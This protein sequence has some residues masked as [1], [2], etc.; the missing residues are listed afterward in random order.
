MAYTQK[1]KF[2]SS[3]LINRFDNKPKLINNTKTPFFQ[4][5]KYQQPEDIKDLVV[6]ETDPVTGGATKA[7]VPGADGEVS[8]ERGKIEETF[9]NITPR[10]LEKVEAEG[11]TPD[12]EGYRQYVQGYNTGALPSQRTDYIGDLKVTDPVDGKP[13]YN[14]RLSINV[15][16]NNPNF[17]DIPDFADELPYGKQKEILFEVLKTRD[18]FDDNTKKKIFENFKKAWEKQNNRKLTYNKPESGKPSTPGSTE[19]LGLT[20]L[21]N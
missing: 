9:E 21:E 8:R 7:Y 10:E 19:Y 2:T 20:E 13:S 4:Q 5:Q 17:Q 1:S 18:E 16:K 3:G 6:T 11:F 15:L 12:L 14:T